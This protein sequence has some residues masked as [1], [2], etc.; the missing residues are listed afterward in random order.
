V[1]TEKR[2]HPTG[3]ATAGAL[4]CCSDRFGIP[5]GRW[6]SDD[7]PNGSVQSYFRKYGYTEWWRS[8]G[9]RTVQN[10]AGSEIAREIVAPLYGGDFSRSERGEWNDVLALPAAA[11]YQ[12]EG[13]ELE[14]VVVIEPRAAEVVEEE[15]RAACER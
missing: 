10:A 15:V 13:V 9:F 11:M 8:A 4:R 2:N 7:V 6:E 12:V 1:F 14:V 3:R 5:L